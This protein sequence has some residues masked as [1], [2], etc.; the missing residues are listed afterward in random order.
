MITMS[1]AALPDEFS[2][3]QFSITTE[4]FA[5]VASSVGLPRFLSALFNCVVHFVDCDALHLDCRQ[6]S[7]TS[8]RTGWIGSFGREP[9]QIN[10]VMQRYYRDY[11]SNDH[12][13]ECIE[14]TREV[15]LMRRSMHQIDAQ[16]RRMFYDVASIHDECVVRYS[17][18]GMQYSLSVCRARRLPPYSL[19]E[20][21]MLKLLAT[22]VLPL[23]ASHYRLAGTI[24]LDETS[25][26]QPSDPLAHF[27]PELFGKLTSREACVCSAFVHG[28]STPA[29]AQSI[30][31]KPSTVETYA[32]R[33]FAKLGIESR[34]QLLAFVFRRALSSSNDIRLN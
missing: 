3:T 13:Y 1:T 18:Q 9:E 16:L 14:D 30:G 15:E 33:A 19:R 12:S 21:S 26:E 27:L 24:R 20:L 34:R 25:A 23:A 2:L 32:K 31:I 10:Q 11:A 7:V 4:A 8:A 28:M 29:I 5:T 6:A 17:A 22:V